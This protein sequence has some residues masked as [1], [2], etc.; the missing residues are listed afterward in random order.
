[1]TLLITACQL[2]ATP[3]DGKVSNT[4]L[5]MVQGYQAFALGMIA[6]DSQKTLDP[7]L[8]ACV[9]KPNIQG[10]KV[11][12]NYVREVF[13]QQE[14]TVL[15]KLFANNQVSELINSKGDKV[16]PDDIKALDN[17][18]QK[19][20]N[21]ALDSGLISKWVDASVSLMDP[22]IA[23]TDKIKQTAITTSKALQFIIN[24]RLVSRR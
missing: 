14:L 12:D 13:S 23:K 17:D 18:S 5:T 8:I 10:Q 9:N 20:L 1:M 7:K 16:T 19:A 6:G 2:S 22:Q 11:A 15:D 4:A 24:E 21:S 3:P